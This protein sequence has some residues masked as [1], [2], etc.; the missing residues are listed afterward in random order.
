M[1]N[2]NEEDRAKR[3]RKLIDSEAETHPEPPFDPAKD[4]APKGGTTRSSTPH[5]TPTPPPPIALDKDNMPLPR[6]VDQVDMGS[7][8]VTPAAY[9]PASRQR[10]GAPQTRNASTPRPSQPSPKRTISLNWM[11]GWGGCLARAFV[12]SL[13]GL[14]ILAIIGASVLMISYYRIAR[15]L[16]TVD[17]LK[18]RLA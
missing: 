5:R 8:R 3:I 18:D 11:S 1:T 13:F 4:D 17:D 16:P 2:E 9:E 10:N 15:T 6:R 7:T 14:V 12:F